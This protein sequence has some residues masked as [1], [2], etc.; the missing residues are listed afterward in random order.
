MIRCVLALFM[1][2]NAALAEVRVDPGR[3]TISDGWW[4]LNI[5]LGLSEVTPYRLFTLDDPYRLVIDLQD[6][7]WEGVSADALLDSGRASAVRF[8]SLR[9]GWSRLVVTLSEPMA[10]A[11][12]GMRTDADGAALAIEL[13]GVSDAA[14]VASAGAP[15][16]ILAADDSA[17]SVPVDDGTRVVV[18]DPGHG[19][20]DPGADQGGVHEAD[21]MLDL[22][23]EVAAA[24]QDV[25]GITVVLTRETDVFV[26]LATRVSL[27]REAGADLLISLHADALEEDEARGAS[28]YTLDAD[29]GD[30][31]SRRMVERH[32]RG[33]ILSGVDLDGQGDLVANVLMDMARQQTWP[34]AAAF[35]DDVV[36]HMRAAGVPLNS[37]PRREGQFAVLVAADFAAVLIEAGFLSDPGDRARLK[38]AEARAPLVRAI[39]AAV[40]DWADG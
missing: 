21:L 27:A 10:V 29:D 18:I 30:A 22:G 6:V 5:A 3:S 8:G 35:A 7:T 4:R 38:T 11:E 33:D 12:A 24:L 37:R 36:A 25:P 19:G 28:V 2:A 39:V 23:L 26:P 40:A 31:A 20:L 15:D 14:F 13:K 32:G 17:P 34:E 1:C 9:D 16:A